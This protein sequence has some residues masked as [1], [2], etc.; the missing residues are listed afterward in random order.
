M[1]SMMKMGGP[2][3]QARNFAVMTG[4]NSGVNTFM[5]R[6]RGVEDIQNTMVA[7]FLS[8]GCFSLVSGMGQTSPTMPGMPAPNPLMGAFSAA[9][10]FSLFQGGFYKLGEMFGGPK[11]EDTEYLRVKAML[12]NLGFSKYE[13][14]VRKALLN[15]TTIM[16]WDTPSLQDAGVPPGPRLLIL[17]HIDLYRNTAGKNRN[18][19]LTP[20]LPVPTAK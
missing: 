1:P 8:G 12:G 10:V 4:V 11:T 20:A 14:N 18:E 15:D 2:M 3:Q 17:H 5:R 13:K 9:V 16:L 19:Y 7:G 6:T